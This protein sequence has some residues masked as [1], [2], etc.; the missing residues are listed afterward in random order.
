M[1]DQTLFGLQRYAVRSAPRS[2]WTSGLERR[3]SPSPGITAAT[4]VSKS[5]EAY[6]FAL[7]RCTTTDLAPGDSKKAMGVRFSL[8]GYHNVVFGNGQIPLSLL[9]RAEQKSQKGTV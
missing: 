5:A 3:R 4:G 6:A 9:E 1:Y 8:K 7:R 2:P